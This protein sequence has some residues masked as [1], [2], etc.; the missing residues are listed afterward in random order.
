MFVAF[1][2]LLRF[3]TKEKWKFNEKNQVSIAIK[4]KRNKLL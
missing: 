4:K 1:L 2:I 3:S